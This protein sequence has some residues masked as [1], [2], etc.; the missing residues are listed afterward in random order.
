MT[1]KRHLAA[2]GIRLEGF[3]F[4]GVRQAFGPGRYRGKPLHVWPVKHC[5]PRQVG[6]RLFTGSDTSERPFF[7]AI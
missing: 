7:K 3:Q 4:R 1:K 6:R 2:W 5:A